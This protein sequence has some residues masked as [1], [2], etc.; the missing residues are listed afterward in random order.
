MVHISLPE[1]DSGR[2]LVFY[3][4]MEEYVAENLDSIAGKGGDAFFL[5][6][7][8]PTVIFG[9]NQ[10]MEAEVNMPYCREKGI[11]L[12]RRKSGG[13]CVYSDWGNIMLSFITPSTDVA[14]TFEK[15]LERLAFILRRAG[16]KAE[17]SGRNDVLVDGKKVSGNAYF[18]QPKTSIVH[19]TMLFD[20]DF[21]ELVKAITPSEAKIKSKGVESVRQHVTNVRPYFEAAESEW[22]RKLADIR[23]YKKYLISEF[24]GIKD[25][26]GRLKALDEVVLTPEQIAEI[27]KIELTY[28]DPA[29]LEGRNHAYSV[30]HKG[31]IEGI[32]EMSIDFDIDLGKIVKCNVSGDYFSVKEGIG[33]YL[34]SLLAGVPDE[35]PVVEAR[36]SGADLAQFVPG[37]DVGSFLSL[38]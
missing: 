4:A 26:N 15:Y 34:T 23:L 13:G 6:Q 19:G 8:P 37:L 7:V 27:E 1:G 11:Q 10:V 32:G 35:R 30:S 36:L 2:R 17:R 16:L 29:F 38:L 24:C 12:Y 18:L 14:F 21:D 20:S 31:K 3:L 28:L 33:E 5:W 22:Q 25:E 9:R